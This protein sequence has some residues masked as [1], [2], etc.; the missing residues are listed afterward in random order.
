M[1]GGAAEEPE[2]FDEELKESV[3]RVLLPAYVPRETFSLS[4]GGVTALKWA[5]VLF[6]EACCVNRK[7]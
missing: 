7:R 5:I 1:G 3:S 2:W 6:R 4:L